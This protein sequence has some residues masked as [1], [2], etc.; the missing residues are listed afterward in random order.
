MRMSAHA[1]PVASAAAALAS[2]SPFSSRACARIQST[3]QLTNT[4]G[5]QADDRLE[6][7][8]L[9]LRE[10]LLGDPQGDP[11]REAERDA[12]RRRPSTAHHISS[13]AAVAGMRNAATI[14]TISDASRPSRR[15][16]T[17]VGKHVR[18]RRLVGG[19]TQGDLPKVRVTLVA[20]STRPLEP[21]PTV[22]ARSSRPDP[23]RSGRDGCSA[24]AVG[25]DGDGGG[26]RTRSSSRSSPSVRSRRSGAAVDADAPV[27]ASLGM[28]PT[29]V[30][31]A[32]GSAVITITARLTDA[33]SPSIGGTAPL[34]RVLLTGP[35]GQQQATAYLSQAQRISGTATDGVYRS[36]L[37]IPWHAA[38]GRWSASAV[39]VDISGNTRTLT[40]ANLAASGFPSGVNQS[41][42]GDTHAPQL[43]AL[44]IA[45]GS[46][47]TSLAAGSVTVSVHAVDDLSGVSDGVSMA[48]SQVVL[49]GPSGAHHARATLSVD[50]R[51][52]GDSSNAT[53]V[54]TVPLPRWSEQG[55]WT[56]EGVTLVDQVGNHQTLTAPGITFTQTGVGDTSA[57]QIRSFSLS[58]R[59]IDVRSAAGVMVVQARIVDDLS[60]AADGLVDSASSVVFESPSGR[61]RMT[62]LFGASQR[63]GGNS[64]DGNYSVT[65]TVAAHAEP[66]VWRMTDAWPID[67]AG[68]VGHLAPGDWA[69]KAFPSAF[70]VVS[71][72][73]PDTGPTVPPD[74]TTTSSTSGSAFT[75]TSFDP[76]ATT[77][78]SFDAA[79]TTTSFDP[80]STTT[81]E[82]DGT[83]TSLPDDT[84][85]PGRHD[86]D[87]A[88]HH[89]DD[90]RRAHGI[91]G[92]SARP[93]RERL[94]V[95]D[96]DRARR[97]LRRGRGVVDLDGHCRLRPRRRDREHA[98]GTRLLDRHGARRRAPLRRRA[99]VRLDVRSA[100]L[101]PDRRHR[102]DARRP[103]VLARRDRRRDLLLR[104]RALLRVDGRHPSES[105]DRRDDLDAERT[106]LLVRRRGRR[107]VQLRR[108][109]VLRF[110]GRDPP[111]PARGRHDAP[112]RPGGATG[113]WRA[114]AAS[115]ASASARFYGSTGAI[116]LNQPI[117]GMSAS[118]T[119]HGYWFVAGDG[120]IFGFGDARF[121]GSLAGTP[122]PVVGMA[123]RLG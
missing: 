69:A 10:I 114:T 97:R 84:T 98:V 48:A 29:A 66:G 33:R 6:L 19:T 110:D 11:A 23:R 14:P 73:P 88:R 21:G 16:I 32:D 35:G 104:R 86:V 107:V 53:F 77:T 45:P 68:N 59:T 7:L 115:S 22:L 26:G 40:A 120:G 90:G 100:A 105:A 72:T 8:L 109:P 13:R 2:R 113:W 67:K 99:F 43:V 108:R 64:V 101:A 103:R 62:A 25:S 46:V 92:A 57:P 82:V 94:L 111:Q 75:T 83:S 106:R 81:T 102:V 121:F 70:S 49:R 52:V 117:V 60:G 63:V 93:E 34:S 5:D 87:G 123:V 85:L 61:Q 80:A 56:V 122:A 51:T 96:R 12:R 28:T 58:A 4:D 74:P 95:R 9:A 47:D 89:D 65:A 18:L 76:S 50:H 20:A 3:I 78:T 17:N 30:D 41:G 91:A 24:P 42:A 37:T 15:P 27:L 54:V 118:P 55:V 38:P 31:T 44:S 71:D 119:A 36:T 39:L 112:R 79:S 1:E 116:H